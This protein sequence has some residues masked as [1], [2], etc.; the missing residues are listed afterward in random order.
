MKL[1]FSFFVSFT[2]F[3]LVHFNFFYL[4]FFYIQC[5]IEVS[6]NLTRYSM[7]RNANK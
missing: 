3:L 7:A 1:S 4:D 5:V 6:K 2:F